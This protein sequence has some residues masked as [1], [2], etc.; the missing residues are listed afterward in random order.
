MGLED[1]FEGAKQLA[2][3]IKNS[4]RDFRIRMTKIIQRTRKS[5]HLIKSGV[6]LE[7]LFELTFRRFS[8]DFWPIFDSTCRGHIRRLILPLQVESKIGSKSPKNRRNVNSERVSFTLLEECPSGRWSTLGKRVNTKVFR[9]FESHLLRMIMK[10]GSE[11]KYWLA[12]WI[13]SEARLRANRP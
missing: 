1:L 5:C 8:E 4:N 9:G 2:K 10:E 12:W 6:A 13:R 11:P 7:T 3:K